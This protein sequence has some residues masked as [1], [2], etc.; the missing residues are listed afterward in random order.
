MA[1]TPLKP[2][3]LQ[4][5][6]AEQNKVV[7][8]TATPSPTASINQAQLE[9]NKAKAAEREAARQATTPT[10]KTISKTINPEAPSFVAIGW[11][12]Y[13]SSDFWD[14]TFTR[15]QVDA[16]TSNPVYSQTTRTTPTV[17]NI[18]P[19]TT[20]K[21]DLYTPPKVQTGKL[22]SDFNSTLKKTG[23]D[24]DAYY[25]GIN[26]A[27]LSDEDKKRAD[28][29]FDMREKAP[30]KASVVRYVDNWDGTTTNYL[31]D[32]TTSIVKYSKNADGSLTPS[33]VTAN[34][35]DTFIWETKTWVD[36]AKEITDKWQKESVQAETEIDT[37]AQKV[38]DEFI[39]AAESAQSDFV[40]KQN[41]LLS[42]YESNRL[43]QVQW[44]IRR[45]LLAR[46]VDISK[47]PQEQL[48]ALSGE[49]GAK[50]FADVFAAKERATAAIENARQNTLAKVQALKTN[51]MISDATYKR[52]VANINSVA[53]QA[54]LN[55]EM[56]W[57]EVVFGIQQAKKAD[58]NTTET[59]TAQAIMNTAKSLWVSGS[60]FGVVNKFIQSAKSTPEALQAMFAELSN[61]NSALY[62][63]LKSNESTAAKQQAFKN[64]I[65]LLEAQAKLKS[66]SRAP[67][68]SSWYPAW[69]ISQAWT[70][71][72]SNPQ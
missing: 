16:I 43:N 47:I 11:P 2:K 67:A 44:D 10:G 45:A 8:P 68:A 46:W 38:N 22:V 3:I 31:S 54:K 72:P 21:T 51:K 5:V 9:A 65:D 64:Q 58:T 36:K 32:W 29:L 61:T 56:K 13:T 28:T 20:A 42:G 40:T 70:N 4:E 34:M 55:A 30:K 59:S 71:I 1:T 37:E 50:A 19:P 52:Q 18:K 35:F 53:D 17:S 15:E 60:Q 6:L 27:W 69:T 66:A 26:Y 14:Q 7:T 39:T 12:Q 25:A 33:E 41:E 49:I 63:I 62:T 24:K 48:I 57:A 23:S